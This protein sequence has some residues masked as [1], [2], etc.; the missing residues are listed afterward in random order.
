LFVLEF[1][2]LDLDAFLFCHEDEWVL[3][4]EG[5]KAAVQGVYLV[6]VGFVLFKALENQ[7]DFVAGISGL[8]LVYNK[9]PPDP[10]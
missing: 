7:L 3:L 4:V 6:I 9:V 10:L 1:E 2:L 8:L 5:L